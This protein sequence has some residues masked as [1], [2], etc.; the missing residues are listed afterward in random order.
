VVAVEERLTADDVDAARRPLRVPRELQERPTA[1]Q[2]LE[3]A[4]A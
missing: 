4:L 3:A 1:A 2:V